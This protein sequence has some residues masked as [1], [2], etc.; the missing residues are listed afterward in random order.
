MTETAT[1][2]PTFAEYVN[3]DETTRLVFERAYP[4]TV[5]ARRVSL[6]VAPGYEHERVYVPWSAEE[7]SQLR[8]IARQLFRHGEWAHTTAL[9]RESCS[10]CVLTGYLSRDSRAD[11]IRPSDGPNYAGWARVYVEAGYAIPAK[12]RRAFARAGLG[13][14]SESPNPAYFDALGRDLVTFGHPGFIARRER[15]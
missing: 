7:A 1:P 5:D 3:G 14:D 8:A 6:G 4:E 10:A 13:D 2:L 12:W 9:E 11:G 15:R